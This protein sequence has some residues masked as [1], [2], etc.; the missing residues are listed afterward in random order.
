MFHPQE[1]HE[2]HSVE[3]E[4]GGETKCSKSHSSNWG[5]RMPPSMYKRSESLPLPKVC[6]ESAS[7]YF[8][9]LSN[10]SVLPPYFL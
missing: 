3:D 9:L 7:I 8:K 1:P 10:Y 5:K 2:V 4:M 6:V